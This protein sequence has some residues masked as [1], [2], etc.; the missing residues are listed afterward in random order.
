MRIGILVLF[1]TV[2]L[3]PPSGAEARPAPLLTV[4]PQYTLTLRIQSD[5]ADPA[6]RV[7]LRNLDT[8]EWIDPDDPA[9][10]YHESWL[11]L[12]YFYARD[13][14]TVQVSEGTYRVLATRGPEYSVADDTVSVTRDTQVRIR[15]QRLFDPGTQGWY[16][17]DTHVHI[18]HGG[19]ADVYTVTPEDMLRVA[20]A[21]GLRVACVLSNGLYFD[22]PGASPAGDDAHLIH[23]G[24]E[25]RS[26]LYGHMGILG[27]PTLLDQGC[28][29]PG[30]PAI[31]LNK[32]VR[33]Q[34]HALGATVI[35][36]HPVT[37]DPD[38]ILNAPLDW[39][40]SG[41]ARELPM[42][43]LLGGVDAMDIYS[44]SNASNNE[45]RKLWFD[46]LNLGY[47]IPLSVG[48]DAAVNRYD[49]PPPGGY[50]VYVHAGSGTPLT[51]DAWRAALTAGRSFGT[52]GP[53][54]V[55]FSLDTRRVGD[56]VD[57]VPGQSNT[58][59][60]ELLLFS[61]DPVTT[62]DVYYRGSV[63]ESFTLPP[64]DGTLDY[65]FTITVPGEP[66]WVVGRVTGPAGDPV[67]VGNPLEATTSPIYLRAGDRPFRP[68]PDAVNRFSGWLDDLTQV[69]Q[70]R[71]GWT[72]PYQMEDILDEV[73][74][75]R[76]TLEGPPAIDHRDPRIE[77]IRRNSAPGLEA[78]PV[79]GGFRF[80]AAGAG[81]GR[82]EVFDVAGRRVYR[83]TVRALPTTF[84]W[85]GRRQGVRL[86]SGIYFARLEGASAP[87]VRI[88]LM[89]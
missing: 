87:P 28:C 33:D 79:E 7:S 14:S 38:L 76:K 86:P 17:G 77:D 39:P 42:D 30:Y 60:G 5:G 88:L 57:L 32:D 46:L 12:N 71:G 47:H 75:A 13:R 25:Y 4:Y 85:D 62:L 78:T 52:N 9:S 83:S 66:G 44:Y 69:V 22:G 74:Q 55:M 26:A 48:T 72:Q 59:A 49:A 64:F 54:P 20:D 6:A 11:G 80:A 1:A 35:F 73:L 51:L 18:A 36:A 43:V 84:R 27:L 21:E 10:L 19:A 65:H 56:T 34:A 15:L 23:F 37:M 24:M 58:L 70:T 29:L 67:L 89:P 31:P 45:A 61:R 68:Y 2:L 3:A 8:G 16:G 53:L 63:L 81:E 50:R 40:Y 82:L 41:F